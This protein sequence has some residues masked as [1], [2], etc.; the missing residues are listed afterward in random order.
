VAGQATIF[1]VLNEIGGTDVAAKICAVH[2]CLGA[3]I[4]DDA[5]FHL[6]GHR[7]AQFVGENEARFVRQ[8]E[9]ARHRQHALTFHLVAEDGD[10]R[11]VAAQGQ[12]VAG[13]QRARRDR[14]ILAA[15]LAAPA[16]RTG[17]AAALVVGERA[18]VRAHGIAG[19]GPADAPEH[20]LGF[21]VRHAEH[22][23]QRQALGCSAEEEVLGHP[24][25]SHP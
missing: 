15:V 7:L 22:L 12:L 1:A 21:R 8:P 20:G 11:E 16:R 9:I 5:A 18:A 25:P 3:I 19:I 23:S 13:E 24:T 17:R 14:E 10:G 6:L 4:T 2:L